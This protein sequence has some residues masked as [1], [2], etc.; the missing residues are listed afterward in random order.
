MINEERVKE[1]YQMALYDEYEDDKCKQTGK[2]FEKDYV[3]KE[4]IIS[5]FT[6]TIAF[7]CFFALWAMVNMDVVQA[8][9]SKFDTVNIAFTFTIVG[10]LY[11]AF[12]IV[13][14]F[15]TI[16]VAQMKYK[17]GRRALKKYEKH[18]KGIASSYSREEKLRS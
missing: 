3:H 7:G 17:R 13:Y 16:V 8:F 5:V 18:L 15:I 2:F 9:M 10:L 12:L 4:I 6:G 14:L 11:V 1:L